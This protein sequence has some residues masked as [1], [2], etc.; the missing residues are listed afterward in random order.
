M[1]ITV[2][3][4]SA[5]DSPPP[6]ALLRYLDV[7]VVLVATVPALVLGAPAFGFVCGA[8]GWIVQR[9]V[10][11]TDR[12][13]TARI[14]DPRRQVG[15]HVAESFGRIWLLAAAIILA[16]LVGGRADGLTAA[17]AIFAAYTV[18]FT[19]RIISG[20]PAASHQ[21]TTEDRSNDR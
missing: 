13:L 16:G 2:T 10:Q 1:A 4:T 9:V 5:S 19:I 20:P 11:V 7:L 12:R 8:G 3:S 6:A 15:V 18:A 21:P 17:I 14:R